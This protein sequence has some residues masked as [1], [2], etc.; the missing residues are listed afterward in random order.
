MFNDQM[1]EPFGHVWTL[2]SNVGSNSV[3]ITYSLYD[4]NPGGLWLPAVFFLMGHTA[5][6]VEDDAWV[7]AKRAG[8]GFCNTSKF[9]KAKPSMELGIQDVLN[10]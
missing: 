5:S 9:Y 3:T 6:Q 1:N 2:E 10:K 7:V 4:Q 8:C